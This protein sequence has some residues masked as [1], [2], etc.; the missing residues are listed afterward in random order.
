M[1]RPAITPLAPRTSQYG[2]APELVKKRLAD[3]PEMTSL[4]ISDLFSDAKLQ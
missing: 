4:M 1:K 2:I 3:Y